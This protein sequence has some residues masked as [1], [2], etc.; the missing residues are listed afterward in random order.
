MLK[1]IL[2]AG[3]LA[4]ASLAP[5][6]RV[7]LSKAEKTN[8][9][10]DKFLY[11]IPFGMSQAEYL[12]EIEVEGFTKDDAAIFAEIYKK[13][14]I[15]GANSFAFL[16]EL[17]IDEKP[18]PLN[19]AHYKLALYYSSAF[20]KEDNIAYVFTSGDQPVKIRVDDK[21]LTLQPRS[22]IKKVINYGSENTITAGGFLG[23]RINLTAK[24]GQAAQYFQ[25]SSFDV[26]SD[27]TGQ[28]GINIKSG[29]IIGLEK[30]YAQFLSLIYNEQKY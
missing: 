3:F 8:T 4:L 22:Y 29:D 16:P 27:Q 17:T 24:D 21:K 30:S 28:G 15:I 26:K 1:N 20:P 12:G 18:A 7:T 2:L 6:Q 25:I 9:N 23:S 13:A 11:R 5:A 19:P 14:K 10:N